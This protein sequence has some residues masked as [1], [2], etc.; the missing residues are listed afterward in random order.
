MVD[1]VIEIRP[2]RSGLSFTT[3]SSSLNDYYT[4]TGILSAERQIIGKWKSKEGTNDMEGAFLLT[5]NPT[6]NVMYG[7]FTT[8]DSLGGVVYATWVL[9][10]MAGA[11]EATIAE[12]LKKA[13]GLLARMTISGPAARP[14][15]P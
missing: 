3:K 11:D 10:K 12:R 1:E 2:G 4:A 5:V 14:T 6:S 15:E 8:P 7:Y 13:Q 9:A